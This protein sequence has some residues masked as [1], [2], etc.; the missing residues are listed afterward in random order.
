MTARYKAVYRGGKLF[1]EYENGELT[2]L[3]PEYSAAKRSDAV[4]A[5]MIIRDIGEYV[6]P[7]DGSTITS[8]S[9]HRDHLR[10]HD[11]VEVGNDM[12]KTPTEDPVRVNRELGEAIK[13]RLDEVVAMPQRQY[14]AHVETQQAEHK[15]IGDL[16]TPTVAA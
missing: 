7:L 16:A 13:R 10:K 3:D 6:S 1:A 12:M 5:P 15:A 2:Y 8:R 14:D 4:H 9:A 11:V